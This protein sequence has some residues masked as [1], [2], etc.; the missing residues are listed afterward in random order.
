MITCYPYIG[1]STTHVFTAEAPYF[2][3]LWGAQAERS[4]KG[5]Y[6]GALMNFTSNTSYYFFVG[7]ST[8]RTGNPWSGGWN[9]GG[10]G[11]GI[12][13]TT[14]ARG[15]G[16]GGMTELRT[17]TSATASYKLLVA[18]G[19]GG[20]TSY[21]SNGG[22][23]EQS[24][25]PQYPS[26]ISD[27]GRREPCGGEG[28][29][30]TKAGAGGLAPISWVDSNTPS[31]TYYPS[32]GGGGGAG[33]Y[34]GGGGST[35]MVITTS[36]RTY[37]AG[38][39]GSQG[40][41]G[42]GGS[43]T[44]AISGSYND[45]NS[46]S[47]G[48]GSNYIGSSNYLLA[49]V[50][51]TA[52]GNQP[53]RPYDYTI[54][55]FHGCARVS[56]IYSVP[57]IKSVERDGDYYIV[58][59]GKSQNN[60][61]EELFYCK[62]TNNAFYNITGLDNIG[63]GRAYTITGDETI[64]IKHKIVYEKNSTIETY[65]SATNGRDFVNK[66]YST[67]VL[68][69]VPTLVAQES[70]LN[71]VYQG[72]SI[73]GLF[74]FAKTE[75]HKGEYRLQTTLTFPNSSQKTIIVEHTENDSIYLPFLY[76]GINNEEYKVNISTRAYQ[77]VDTP[78]GIGKE[79]EI[80][81]FTKDNIT[82]KVNKQELNDIVIQT[83]LK[84][85]KIE[86]DTVLSLDWKVNTSDLDTT[87]KISM[88]NAQ[89]KVAQNF[90]FTSSE[91]TN[92]KKILLSYPQGEYYF[93]IYKIKNGVIVTTPI[94]TDRFYVYKVIQ[95]TDIKF[96][97]LNLQTYFSCQFKKIVVEVNEISRFSEVTNLNTTLP[98]WI[99]KNGEN[100]V[101]IKIFFDDKEY[102]SYDYR[103]VV[104]YDIGQVESK[105]DMNIS[106]FYS[107]ND[108][109]LEFIDLR[110]ELEDMID[111]EYKEISFVSKRMNYDIVDTITQKFIISKKEG[112]TVIPQ[113]ATI[114][115]GIE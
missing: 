114:T 17:N 55:Y 68:I 99:F 2:V 113:I 24:G 42:S 105:I 92:Q 4:E 7:G 49:S 41:G 115:G 11:G 12:G 97:D 98:I 47:G 93:G 3:E 32:S 57:V 107:I 58:E 66:T 51:S 13:S 83:D 59:I 9:G 86:K 78:N 21:S 37:S 1:A 16:G 35:G 84:N 75:K 106:S 109:D 96:T 15:Y 56:Q 63:Y 62:V 48:G 53:E 39:A 101:A 20:G 65:V 60:G 19:S 23:A 61:I 79:I 43:S 72:K 67:N 38:G 74:T 76:D 81:T 88:F 69:E 28:A 64:T 100:K 31:A 85:K 52:T 110:K 25:Q 36:A 102:V 112:L 50:S 22:G 95:E 89:D 45:P 6:V 73:E 46:G 77:A 87:Y 82:V 14:E 40:V 8:A 80:G 108:N 30:S 29:T 10:S 90:Y 111:L 94:F 70:K 104:T 91:L 54:N 26:V 34:G 71:E 5:G 44:S 18:G 27:D 103:A 33:Y